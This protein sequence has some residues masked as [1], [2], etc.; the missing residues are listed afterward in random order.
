[1]REWF[2]GLVKSG[3]DQKAARRPP[4]VGEERM[5]PTGPGGFFR[6]PGLAMIVPS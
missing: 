5:T 3:V 2:E 1:M 4:V 6:F